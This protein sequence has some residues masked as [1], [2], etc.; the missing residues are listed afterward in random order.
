M[1]L[2]LI[3]LLLTPALAHAEDSPTFKLARSYAER[4]ADPKAIPLLE[5]VVKDEPKNAEAHVLLGMAYARQERRPEAE[6]EVKL[7]L[8][9]DPKRYDAY[10][11]LG[12]LRDLASDPAGA[13]A[14]Y[15][16]AMTV[17]P[18]RPEAYREAGSSELLTGQADKAAEHLAHAHQL[19]PRDLDITLDLGQALVQ[20]KQCAQAEKLAAAQLGQGPK[21]STVYALQGD[22]LACQGKDEP[23][24]AAYTT[25]TQ[26]D[27]QNGQAWFHLG[28]L[29][30]KRNQLDAAKA[31]LAQ[32]GALLPKDPEVQG[33]LQKYGVAA[34][35]ARRPVGPVKPAP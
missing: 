30:A 25:A 9:A 6:A 29:Q 34:P 33:A 8:A 5:K 4:G 19:L 11:V 27:A 35:T 22:A 28:L 7:A 16:Q 23:A 2:A 24:A 1:R 15:Q 18:A 31:A 32:A 3:G 20:A 14:V 21:A 17:D 10:L 13:V 12:M 26:T